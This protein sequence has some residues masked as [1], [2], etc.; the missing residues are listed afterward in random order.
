MSVVSYAAIIRGG[1]VIAAMGDSS[2]T[3]EHDI[4][5]IV[6]PSGSR[7]EQR[8]SSGLLYTFVAT[9][10]LTY[11]AVSGVS[12]DKQK[13]IAFLNLISRR[14]A[15]KFGHVSASASAHALDS[16]FAKN[17]GKELDD[18][19]RDNRTADIAREINETH[20][21]LTES[22]TKALDRGADLES[23]STKS[24]NLMDTS[25]EFRLEATN[26]KRKMRCQYIKSWAFQIVLAVIV[27]YIILTCICG[28]FRLSYCI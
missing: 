13:P 10:G 24:E 15:A 12:V 1:T 19:N 2:V 20:K 8:I 4:L 22:V 9:P 17:F 27:I 21:I 3:S 25:S 18:V 16:V 7:T 6:L 14:W 11:V 28:G 26:L 23:L 5:K